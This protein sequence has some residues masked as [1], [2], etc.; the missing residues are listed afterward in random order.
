[1]VQRV[2]YRRKLHYN[3]RSNRTT[4]AK[5]PGGK[6]SVHY[7]KKSVKGPHTPKT[8][9]HKRLPGTKCLRIVDAKNKSKRFKTVNRAYGGVLNHKQV[10]DRILRAFVCEEQKLSKKTLRRRS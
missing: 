5:T 4:L 7:L 6:I 10:H 2:H 1:M 8:L 9:G 3:T